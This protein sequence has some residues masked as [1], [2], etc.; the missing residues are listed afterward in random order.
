M[1]FDN[2]QSIN[3]ESNDVGQNLK[4]LSIN[5]KCGHGDKL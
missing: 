2:I 5:F 1:V 4:F 3:N